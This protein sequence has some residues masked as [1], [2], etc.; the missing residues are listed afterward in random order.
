M[1]YLNE[2]YITQVCVWL[3]QISNWDIHHL[4]QIHYPGGGVG[5]WGWGVWCGN[6]RIISQIKLNKTPARR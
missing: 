6:I 5:G 2:R 3:S 4:F 1:Q